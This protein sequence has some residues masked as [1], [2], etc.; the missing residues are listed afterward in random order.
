[1]LRNPDL[2]N[3][4]TRVFFFKTAAFAYSGDFNRTVHFLIQHLR[5][6]YPTIP[7]QSISK[8]SRQKLKVIRKSLI[9][10]AI[11]ILTSPT[12]IKRKNFLE[13][14]FT[15]EEGT[16]LGPTLEF[17]YLC[18]KEFRRMTDIWRET[19]D[20]SLFPLPFEI[21]SAKYGEENV[22]KFFEAMG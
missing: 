12:T 19:Q 14:E 11:E 18:S 4:E 20:N 7:E 17:Y 2:L 15:N 6:K 3:F 8:Q 16:G 9:E 1:M 21:S 10:N 5:K 13:I 22:V